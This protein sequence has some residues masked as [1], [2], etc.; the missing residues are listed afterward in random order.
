MTGGGQRRGG[1][2]EVGGECGGDPIRK[3]CWVLD[4][5]AL[6]GCN[7]RMGKKKHQQPHVETRHSKQC[8][9]CLHPNKAEIED[10]YRSGRSANSIEEAFDD[11]AN[12][13]VLRHMRFYGI[14]LDIEKA[15][16]A[17]AESGITG[18]KEKSATA[19]HANEALKSL[20]KLRGDWVDRTE[21]MPPGW[22]D[23][24]RAEIEFFAE[25]GRFPQPGE[26][27]QETV[28]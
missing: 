3:T 4:Q 11:L 8:S 13:S 16:V 9:V 22:Q 23:R 10:L 21:L 19:A 25:N 18:L 12:G 28:Q 6:F 27:D 5:N 2:I 1:G 24:N 15:L 26:I 17:I 20:A 14:E 7:R